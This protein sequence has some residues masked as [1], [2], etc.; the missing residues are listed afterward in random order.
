VFAKPVPG[1]VQD[2]VLDVS[3]DGADGSASAMV[4]D[5]YD[6][7]VSYCELL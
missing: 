2:P 5:G 1:S 7:V 3:V 4:D 6:D